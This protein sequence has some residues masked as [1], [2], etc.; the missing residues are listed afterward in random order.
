[1][2]RS[3]ANKKISKRILHNFLFTVWQCQ[4]FRLTV[5]RNRIKLF[6]KTKLKLENWKLEHLRQCW[7]LKKEWIEIWEEGR[8]EGPRGSV[9]PF[10][11]RL[12]LSFKSRFIQPASQPLSFFLICSLTFVSPKTILFLRSLRHFLRYGSLNSI[13]IFISVITFFF[14]F[15]C[16]NPFLLLRFFLLSNYFMS[17]IL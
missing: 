14:F 17:V 6:F 16:F 8:R 9:T 12:S 1:M 5:Y 7:C 4:I 13:S 11:F 15:F 3:V 2:D 10:Y